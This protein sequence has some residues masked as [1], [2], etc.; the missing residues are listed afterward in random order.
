MSKITGL[1]IDIE[2]NEARIVTVEDTLQSYYHILNCDL[3]D[4]QTRFIGYE[5]YTVVCDDEGLLKCKP[6][7]SAI[8]YLDKPM[9]V[10]NLFVVK[11]DEDNNLTSLN[12]KDIEHLRSYFYMHE[13]L[14]HPVLHSVDYWRKEG[15]F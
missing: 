1:L 8:N 12:D 11:T 9:F 15:P 5:T 3:I 10:G 14:Q 7:I 4:I 13:A 2:S 6:I